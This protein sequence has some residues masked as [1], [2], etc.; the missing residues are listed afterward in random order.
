MA[1]A[2][3]LISTYT[4]TQQAYQSQMATGA[5]GNVSAPVR[6]AIAAAP[7]VAMGLARVRQIAKV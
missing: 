1:I 6:A 7:A 3:T 2:S 4:A 5:L